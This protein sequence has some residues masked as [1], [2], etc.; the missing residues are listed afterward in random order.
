MSELLR[1]RINTLRLRPEA[2]FPAACQ[3]HRDMVKSWRRLQ[4]LH[5]AAAA[6]S[7]TMRH[8]RQMASPDLQDDPPAVLP[9]VRHKNGTKMPESP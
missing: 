4:R 1:H 6:G 9:S 3:D 8:G 5:L 2:P 7:P